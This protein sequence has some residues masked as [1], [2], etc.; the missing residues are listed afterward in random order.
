MII[1]LIHPGSGIGDQLF[2]YIATRTTAKRL[3]VSF[4]FIG[5]PK[6]DF[7]EMDMGESIHKKYQLIARSFKSSSFQ[8]NITTTL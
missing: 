3:G 6:A 5:V 2:S 8:V 1:G 7:I 4:G